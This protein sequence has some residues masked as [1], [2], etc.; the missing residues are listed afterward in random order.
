MIDRADL[1]RLISDA[2]NEQQNAQYDD[3]VIQ[4]YPSEGVS[5]IDAYIDFGKVADAVLAALQNATES[6]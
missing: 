2:V 4:A 5:H 1:V 6:T 3:G